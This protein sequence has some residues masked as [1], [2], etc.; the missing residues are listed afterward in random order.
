[1]DAGPA[2]SAAD[3]VIVGAGLAGLSAARHL[4]HAGLDTVICEASDEVG[5]RVRTDQVDGFRLDRGFQVLLPAYPELRQQADIAALQP[6]PFLRGAVVVTAQGRRWLAAPWH[7]AQ[8]AAGL[9]GLALS[10]PAGSAA[11]AMLSLRDL[12]SPATALRTAAPRLTTAQELRRWRLSDTVITEVMRPFLAGVFLDP[13]LSSPARLFHLIWR[14]FLLGGG[15]LPAGGIQS[16]PQ[17]LA[18]GLPAASVR[19]GTEI[20]EI[21][22]SGVRTQAGERIQ[23]RAVI[24]ATDGDT[25]AQLAPGLKAPT[26]HAV[27]TFYYRMPTSPLRAPALIIDGRDQLLV[28]TAVLS[29]VAPTYAPPGSAL[30]AASVPGRADASLQARVRDRLSRLYDTSTRDWDLLAAYPIP[31]ALPVMAPRQTLTRPVRLQAGRY[32]C[33]DH[34]D[35]PSVQGAL[36]SGRRAAQALLADLHRRPPA[37][38]TPGPQVT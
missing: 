16:L 29:D 27:T 26:W 5:G 14:S 13:E 11:L 24:V 8:A 12:L 21:T 17:Q 22:S 23:A 30:V 25:A 18:A 3:V 38:A 19:T 7:R 10:Q 35:T 4:H 15:A 33:G 6:Q 31:H 37:P 1:M 2:T 28:N 36:V 32:V 20:A 9:M 34:R